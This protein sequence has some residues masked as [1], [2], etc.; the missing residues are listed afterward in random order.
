MAHTVSTRRGFITTSSALAATSVLP[1]RLRAAASDKLSL[2][3]IGVGGRGGANLGGVSHENI[4]VLCDT[5]PAALAAAGKR[6]PNARRVS[7]WREVVTDAKLDGVVISTAD[8][9]HAPI[10]VAAMRQNKHVYTEKPLGHT[11]YEARLMQ[12]EYK[13]RRGKIATQMGTQ[14]HATTTIGARLSWSSRVPS[15]R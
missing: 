10:A 8:H 5:N 9:H 1:V 15:A 6:Y 14:I 7:D 4:A 2:G 11:V 3:I 12:D 13:K